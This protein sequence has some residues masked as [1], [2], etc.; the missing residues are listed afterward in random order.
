MD[1]WLPL[2]HEGSHQAIGILAQ[3]SEITFP[4]QD[5]FNP[6]LDKFLVQIVEDEWKRVPGRP[7]NELTAD[8]L[9]PFVE[10][11][12]QLRELLFTEIDR[13][14][15]LA[16][17]EE[18]IPALEKR[19]DNGYEGPGEDIREAVDGLVEVLREPIQSASRRSTYPMSRQ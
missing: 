13:R 15:V 5:G 14:E 7:L 2:R 8:L 19:R 6:P 12:I 3:V 18:V 16:A 17:V 10:V 11:T 9:E 4:E 1:I